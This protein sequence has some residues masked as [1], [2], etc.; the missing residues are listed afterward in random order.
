MNDD[1][2]AIVIGRHTEKPLTEGGGI[3]AGQTAKALGRLGFPTWLISINYSKGIE[4]RRIEVSGENAEN[5]IPLKIKFLSQDDVLN[6]H[7]VAVLANLVEFATT[8][9]MLVKLIKK[10][11]RN[12][13]D[14]YVFIVNANKLIGAILAHLSKYFSSRV[15]KVYVLTRRE[16]L[17]R[18]TLRMIKPDVILATSKEL[19]LM[20]F[21]SA[22]LGVTNIL[23][24]Y[25]PI[26]D[27]PKS[28]LESERYRDKEPIL[29]YLGRVNEKRFPVIFFK[30]I[31]E[32]LKESKEELKFIIVTPPE[33][34]SI[35]WLP[36]AKNIVEEFNL[37]DRVIFVPRIL[38]EH[39]KN[40][41]LRKTSIFIYP[42]TTT[43]AI[44]PPLSALEAMSYGQYL[45]TTG[46]TS[47]RELVIQ[48]RGFVSKDFSDLNLDNCIYIANQARDII[49]SWSR[50]NLS[51]TKFMKTVKSI[52]DTN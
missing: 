2:V 12:Y 44:E 51:V 52:T 34:P 47:T 6:N 23:F 39:E 50:I 10:L 40:V 37:V 16:E 41:L 42:S 35:F 13:R 7:R 29:L 43:A 31:A 30:N 49:L 9:L 17:Y 11:R 32:K 8:P 27:E 45:I 5:E 21:K 22:I 26:L 19:Q 14:V 38:R 36:K 48:T 28:R 25:P 3:I 20:A 4:S 18:E 24:A 15:T 33:K 1:V 46:S